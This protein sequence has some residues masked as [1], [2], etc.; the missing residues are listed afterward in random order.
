[1]IEF[2]FFYPGKLKIWC[3]FFTGNLNNLIFR[4][5]HFYEVVENDDLPECEEEEE[6]TR[7]SISDAD[8]T[9]YVFKCYDIIDGFNVITYQTEHNESEQ[10]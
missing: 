8:P 2:G 5:S 3:N 7:Q 1:M 9:T 4:L 10:E 6:N